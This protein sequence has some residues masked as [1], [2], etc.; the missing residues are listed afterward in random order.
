MY[1]QYQGAPLEPATEYFV[2][3]KAWNK[4]GSQKSQVVAPFS[5][6]LFPTEADPQ[7]W[8]GKWIGFNSQKVAPEPS[9]ITKAH[10]IAY[11]QNFQLPVGPS[12]YRKTF[13]IDNV[14]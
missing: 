1:I 6:G 12:V 9:D 11:E 8:K 7:P 13:E 5:T 3:L 4:D 14:D 10:W 2:E